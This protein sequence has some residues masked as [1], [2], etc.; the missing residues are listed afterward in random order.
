M[1]LVGG[2]AFAVLLWLATIGLCAV[3]S[4]FTPARRF[5]S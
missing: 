3:I 4:A 2:L 1:S 5:R